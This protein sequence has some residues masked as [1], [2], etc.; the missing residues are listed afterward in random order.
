MTVSWDEK[1]TSA[2]VK[3]RSY[4]KSGGSKVF[5][6][7]SKVNVDRAQ[8][9]APA[10]VGG[11]TV[12]GEVTGDALSEAERKVFEA[13]TGT[14]TGVTYTPIAVLATQVVAG[15]N[16]AFLA[17]AKTLVPGS[18]AYWTVVKVYKDLAGS[19]TMTGVK[20]I[21]PV[22][23]ATAGLSTYETLA[24]GWSVPDA[25][26][27]AVTVPEDAYAA[28]SKANAYYTSIGFWPAALLARQ[29]VSGT[30]YRFICLGATME[31]SDQRAIWVI[32]VSEDLEGSA[33]IS[34]AVFLDILT[35]VGD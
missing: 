10:I 29:V 31:G 19:C 4:S 7:W 1:A 20:T 15:T 33:R 6:S 8:A 21:D 11:W 25:V 32:D 13:A 18:E 5:G 35:Y 9:E 3:V 23:V 28:F 24:G 30:N 12:N 26:S 27:N 17:K 2:K 22:N 34:E 16:Y 14:L